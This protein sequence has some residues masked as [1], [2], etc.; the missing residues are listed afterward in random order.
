MTDH[1]H[2]VVEDVIV[3]S[4]DEDHV[5]GGDLRPTIS[6]ARTPPG[7]G[8]SRAR[9]LRTGPQ[10]HGGQ[11]RGAPAQLGARVRPSSATGTAGVPTG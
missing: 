2:Q 3:E 9:P 11:E 7:R 6:S 1:V 8:V 4:I 10:Q 5:P